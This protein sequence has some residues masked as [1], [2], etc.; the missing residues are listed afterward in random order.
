VIE[1]GRTI[2]IKLTDAWPDDLAIEVGRIGIA[3]AQLTREVYLAA[4]RKHGAA[5]PDWEAQNP[6]DNLS[7]WIGRLRRDFGD[8]PVLMRLID[9]A[10]KAAD[11][12]HD[13]F[14]AIWGRHGDGSLNRWRRHASSGIEVEPMEALL[15]EIRDVR[16]SINRHTRAKDK[17]TLKETIGA[18]H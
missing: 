2:A 6:S 11:Q 17:Y 9:R 16:D 18:A 5:L 14:H 4:K 15:K 1:K 3:F 7:K 12:R 10:E 13:V 8:D